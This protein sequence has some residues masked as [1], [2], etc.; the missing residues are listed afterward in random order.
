M[1]NDQ[2]AVWEQINAT[3]WAAAT[4]MAG[5]IIAASQRPHSIEEAYE[6]AQ[7]CYFRLFPAIGNGAYDMW[8]SRNDTREK[9]E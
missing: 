3:R 8:K 6:L 5:G 1:A 2:Q 4:A 7:S 9:H